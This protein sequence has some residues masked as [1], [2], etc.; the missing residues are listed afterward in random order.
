MSPR[1]PVVIVGAGGHAKVCIE[2]LRAQGIYL[3]C[4]CL[5]PH[6]QL[7]RVLGVPVLGA[8]TTTDEQLLQEQRDAGIHHVF[9]AIGPN[10]LRMRLAE[11]AQRTG[12]E[13]VNAVS[14]KAVVSPSA[15][16]GQG[17]L[18][19]PGAVIN[20]EATIGDYAIVNTNAVVEHDCR[21]GVATHIASCAALAGCVRIGERAFIGT[22]ASLKPGIFVGDDAVVG[23]G[24]A[25]VRDV[26]S[27]ATVAGV[28]ARTLIKD[29]NR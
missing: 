4:A 24:A 19:M 5:D 1:E 27:G 23:A 17:V 22:G 10:Q 12:F 16:I 28:P 25:V 7:D 9:I 8:S 26:A 18:I 21:L 3:P 13:I 2:V 15:K 14:P 11:L 6:S 20:A 29:K